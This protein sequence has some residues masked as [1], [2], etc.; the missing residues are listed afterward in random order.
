MKEEKKRFQFGENWK[1]FLKSLNQQKINFSKK[2]LLDF[3]SEKDLDDKTF[4]DVGSGSGLSSLVA[5]IAGAEVHSFDY[6]INSVKCTEH[7]KK[8]IFLMI[9]NGK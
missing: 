3:L 2:S 4:L 7:L 6:D 8:P 1:I 5:K 9:L